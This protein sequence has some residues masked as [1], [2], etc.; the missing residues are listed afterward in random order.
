MNLLSWNCRGGG[1]SRTVREVATIYQSHSPT[2]VFLCETRQKADKLKRIRARLGLK[3]FCGVD[4][5]GMSGGL[6]LY[7][8]E[9]YD[10]QILD[11]KER[12]IDALVRIHP[13]AEQWRVTC[14]YGEPRVENRPAMWS[15][16]QNLKTVIDRPWLVVGDFNEAMWNFE[17][18]SATPRPEAQMVAFRDVLEV[19]ELVDLG[20]I[21]V[22]FTYDNKRSGASNVKVRLDRAV[23]SNDWRNSFAYSS[24]VHIPSPC[25]DHIAILVKG[26]ADPGPTG[27]SNRR[28]ELFWERDPMLPD[29]IKEAWEAVGGVQNLAQLRDALS[30]TMSSLGLWSKKLVTSGES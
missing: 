29:I 1:N 2:L 10:V 20:F 14:V 21:G 30:K 27:K 12:Y 28:Y 24:V 3:G 23:A 13:D 18:M 6:A 19:C 15:A 4:S 11:K 26:S 9:S 16:L 25:S 17:H 5:N 22:P 7:W 8:H